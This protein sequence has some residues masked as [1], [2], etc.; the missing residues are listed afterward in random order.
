MVE[1]GLISLSAV[2][3]M[4]RSKPAV[5]S[6]CLT[7]CMIAAGNPAVA[8][9]AGQAELRPTDFVRRSIEVPAGSESLVRGSAAERHARQSR[10]PPSYGK[11]FELS[12][13]PVYAPSAQVEGRLRIW[14]NNY[15]L[16]SGVAAAWEKEFEALN[17]GVD[18]EMVLPTAAVATASLYMGVADL[19]LTHE[20]TFY[21]SLSH[22]RILGYEPTGFKAFTGSYDQ[23]GWMNSI[24]VIVH[25][26][27]P[28]DQLTLDQL[29]GIFGS[30]R[31]GGWKGTVWHPEFARGPEKNIRTWGQ[32]GLTGNWADK[33]ITPYGYAVVY[34]TA[35]EFSRRVL[36]S[37][38]RW[39]EKL[40]DYGNSVRPDGSPYSQYDQILDNFARDPGG[41][42][43]IRY[44]KAF[45]K[46]KY[47]IVK[48][49]R[50][51]NSPAVEFTL[52]NV[53]NR[54]YPLS[55]E[56]SFWA[57]VEPGQKM[58]PLARE[59]VSY[60]LSR[61]GQEAIQNV[62]RKYLP[63]NARAVAEE[64]ARLANY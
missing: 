48:L 60:I 43:Y 63:L 54:S 57:S 34:A 11:K 36:Q 59:F 37:S 29:D 64:R 28:L 62:D 23:S 6:A 51:A 14:G 30:Q 24:A 4:A 9:P 20:P 25:N 49:A 53:F 8:Q 3:R 19:A 35:T 52:D 16:S 55:G 44:Q 40:K 41:I 18:V 42:A 1:H 2:R 13:L 26:D 56:M 33:P 45:P 47:K 7:A 5:L 10:L 39:N 50:D 22:L 38:G 27:N 12:G 17:P 46:D 58:N 61:Q 32:L 15:I 31:E 21:D